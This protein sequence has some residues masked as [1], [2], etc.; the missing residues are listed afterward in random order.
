[1]QQRY[2]KPVSVHLADS[3][4]QLDPTSSELALCP[5]FYWSERGAQFVVC[6]VAASRYRCQFFYSDGEQYGTGRPEYDNLEN[7][8][9][10]LLQVQSDHERQSSLVSTSVTAAGRV[11]GEYHGPVIV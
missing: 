10:T 6:K 2:S 9:M 5:T 11:E 4:L 8:V 1:M 3:E 7:C